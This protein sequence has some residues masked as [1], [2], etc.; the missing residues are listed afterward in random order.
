MELSF[1][2]FDMILGMD[3]LVKHRVGLDCESKRVTFKVEDDV[4]VVMVGERRVYLS[5]VISALGPKKLIRKGCDAYLAYV[6]DTAEWVQL[7]KRF[8]LLDRG[9][10]RPNVSPWGALVLFVKKKDGSMRMCLKV[11]E[12]DV[13]KTSFRTRYGHYEF[14][15]TPFGLTNAPVAFNDI[16]NWV[17]QPYIDHFIVM[18]INDI[19][20]YSKTEDEHG[21]HLQTILQI[22]RENREKELNAK[23]SKSSEFLGLKRYYRRFVEGFSLIAAPLTKLLRAPIVIQLEP[24]KEFIVHSD[25]SYTVLGFVMMQEGKVVAY[26]SRQLKQHEGNYLTHDLKLATRELNL[27]Q[28]HWIEL[29]KDYDCSIEYHLG[30]A[31]MVADAL[32]QRSMIDLRAIFA[33]LSLFD[34]GRI[35]AELQVK[36]SWFWMSLYSYA[37][38]PGGNKMYSDL[39]DL[40]WW[41]GLRCEIPLQKWERVTMDFISGL[42]LTPTKMDS[43]WVIIDRLTESAH[44]ISF[45]TNYSLQK[46]A[47][48][49]VSEIVKL[50]RVPMFIISDW[51]PCFVSIF[52]KSYMRLWVHDWILAQLFILRLMMAHYEALYGRKCRTPLCWTELGERKV[53]GPELVAETEDKVHFI[54][55]PLQATFDR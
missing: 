52:G 40:Y 17:F 7:C 55:D 35:L 9:F 50:Y 1:G 39:C 31:N 4:E 51:D 48:L 38:H 37:M 26:A 47:K 23:L 45:R 43:I 53:L 49:Y 30:T 10:I 11:K 19:L 21:K 20:V 54:Q 15:V 25:A 6:H 3:W 16:I 42:P 32:S 5:H 28:R 22:L 34:D 33:C 29:L 44:F 8:E 18:L 2:E 12:V 27:R 41:L 46:L 13:H 14:L 36:P 24:G